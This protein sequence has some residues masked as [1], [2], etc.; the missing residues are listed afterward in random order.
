M[1]IP[2]PSTEKTFL[3]AWPKF[4]KFL[5]SRGSDILPTTNPFELARFTTDGSVGIVY[6]STKGEIRKSGWTKSARE[7]FIAYKTNSSTWRASSPTPRSSCK[8]RSA[9]IR[10]TLRQRDGDFCFFCGQPLGNNATIEH[11]IPLSAGG[12]DTLQNMVL[13]HRECNN[14]AGSMTVTEKIALRDEKRFFQG[15]KIP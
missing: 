9:K 4:A 2:F 12:P 3:K 14:Q 1:T 15:E 5:K 6:K 7:A 13:A 10:R 11:L 8:D